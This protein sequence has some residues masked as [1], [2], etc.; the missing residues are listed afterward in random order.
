A[1]GNGTEVVT[2]YR[3]HGL[4]TDIAI[5]IRCKGG[6]ASKGPSA[7]AFQLTSSLKAF[8]LVEHT[9]WEEMP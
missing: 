3:R 5:H 9:V 2:L 6:A 8:G 4:E 1:E 7:L